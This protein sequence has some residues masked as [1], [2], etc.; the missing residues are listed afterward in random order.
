MNIGCGF[1]AVVLING[2]AIEAASGTDRDG[3]GNASVSSR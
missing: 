3:S 2:D 1:D